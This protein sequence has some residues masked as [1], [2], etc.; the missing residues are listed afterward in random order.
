MSGPL[1]CFSKGVRKVRQRGFL[2]PGLTP[3][4]EVCAVQS[5]GR[6]RPRG[7]P[8]WNYGRNYSRLVR[9]AWRGP[10]GGK[11]S[12]QCTQEK[13]PV[14]AFRSSGYHRQDSDGPVSSLTDTEHGSGARK[15][16]K[17]PTAK[18]RRNT[19]RADGS[20]WSMVLKRGAGSVS[21]EGDHHTLTKWGDQNPVKCLRCWAEQHRHHQTTNSSC[22]T[23]RDSGYRIPKDRQLT[24]GTWLL[25]GEKKKLK[26]FSNK[27][28]LKNFKVEGAVETIQGPRA[29]AL[30]AGGPEF[31]S[32]H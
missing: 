12:E 11:K 9:S 6:L 27:F 26:Y 31:E 1:L 17:W 13:G 22:E 30:Q 8:T 28:T 5:R 24:P 16:V 21:A 15:Q 19:G 32:Q 3:R 23:S 29:L 4:E 25:M 7:H 14:W 20:A 18:W 10:T 2:I